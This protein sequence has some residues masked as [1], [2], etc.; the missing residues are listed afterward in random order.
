[1][2]GLPIQSASLDVTPAAKALP[3][4]SIDGDHHRC[5]DVGAGLA[6]LV[7]GVMIQGGPRRRPNA[8]VPSSPRIDRGRRSA[9]SVS[10]VG[11]DVRG[12]SPP[13]VPIEVGDPWAGSVT[14]VAD[15]QVS[16]W[17]NEGGRIR[18]TPLRRPRNAG[19]PGSAI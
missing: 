16:R 9:V 3:T 8:P 18:D 6:G 11:V 2:P 15:P 10:R 13:D 17:E 7:L 4:V 14:A 1:M 5:A 12:S 19:L